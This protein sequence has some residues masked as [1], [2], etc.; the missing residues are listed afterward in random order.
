MT[1]LHLSLIH[2]SALTYLN[3]IQQKLE[4]LKI[5][6]IASITGRYYAMDRDRRWERIE[7]AY[8]ALTLGEG[9]RATTWKEAV[10]NAY[11]KD[12]TDEFIEPTLIVPAGTEPTLIRQNDSVIFYN[13]RIDSPVSYTHLDVY[14]RQPS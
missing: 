6:R 11:A 4:Q 13:F 2:I 3:D 12:I 8:K 7:K 5:G 9:L 1:P 14:K 10:E